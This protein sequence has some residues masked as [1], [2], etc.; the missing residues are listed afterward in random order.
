MNNF[1][2]ALIF[3]LLNIVFVSPVA[4]AAQLKEFKVCDYDLTNKDY[5]E[6][7]ED[8]LKPV[9]EYKTTKNKIIIF[10]TIFPS[11]EIFKVR[12]RIGGAY[13]WVETDK[14]H[15]F[16]YSFIPLNGQKYNVLLEFINKYDQVLVGKTF[17]LKY[18][19]INFR[20]FFE[21]LVEKLR[22]AYIERNVSG[23]ISFLDEYEYTEIEVFQKNLE[24]TYRENKDIYLNIDIK[25]MDMESV[26]GMSFIKIDWHKTFEGSSSQSGL[27]QVIQF[28]KDRHGEWKVISLG[29]DDSMFVIGTGSICVYS[30]GVAQKQ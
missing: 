4:L 28:K 25:D 16:T 19:A 24:K 14:I 15:P 2:I 11:S 18:S 10:S 3:V 12:I 7:N 30:A 29:D 21:G 27:D 5:I 23:L 22:L 13:E 9:T 6:I 26:S 17:V 8:D 1:I 20:E